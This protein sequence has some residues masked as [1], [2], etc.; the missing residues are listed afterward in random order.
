MEEF[1]HALQAEM[2][3]PGLISWYHLVVI[4]LTTALT[5]LISVLFKDAKE[6][7][8]KRILLIFW[9]FVLFTGTIRQI[10]KS[11]HYGD[12]SYWEYCYEDFPVA[13]CSMIYYFIP[14][15]LFVN[16]E[17]HPKIVDTAIGYMCL[18]SLAAGLLVCIYTSMAAGKRVFVNFQTFSHH[19]IQVVLGVYIF[20]WNRKSIT[21]K[22]FYRTIIAFLITVAIAIVIN[23]LFYPH[24]TN[25]FYINP[26]FITELPI[27]NVIQEKAGYAVFL[28]VYILTVSLT[29]YLTY[30]VET[31]IYKYIQKRKNIVNQEL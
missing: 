4:L 6:K 20:V 11:F 3:P 1:L 10:I 5:I 29:T 14:I 2:E 30:L 23:L 26:L 9:I 8:Y 19:G 12:P 7:T 22:T 16:K 25:M 28:L 15:I 31:S 18:I 13:L 27:G 17:K 24:Y 21:I